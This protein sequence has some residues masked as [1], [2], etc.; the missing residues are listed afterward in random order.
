[1][2]RARR[3]TSAT[4]AA[5]ALVLLS[6]TA[7]GAATIEVEFLDSAGEGFFDSDF[8]VMAPG[9][10]SM[11]RGG[12]RQNVVE[13]AVA[14]WERALGS[15]VTITVEMAMDELAP[16]TASGGI[17]GHAGA[18]WAFKNFP[19]APLPSTYYTVAEANSLAGIDLDAGPDIE[20]AFNSLVDGDDTCFTT[21]EW[22]Y[23]IGTPAPAGKLDFYRVVLHEIG[24]GL[25]ITT[26]V[27]L[28]TGAKP[29]DSD[30]VYMRRL[31]D[32]SSGKSWP[33]MTNAERAASAKDTGD[34]HWIG[35]A[36]I[37]LGPHVVSGM[38][39]GGHPPMYAPATL[40]P[41]S[42]V[43][44]WATGIAPNEF[45]EPFLTNDSRDHLTLGLLRDIGWNVKLVFA[46]DF[47]SGGLGAW[48]A[49]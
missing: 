23:G 13:A 41:G 18:K 37:A 2:T 30:D 10:P 38:G 39:A 45:M 17:L 16:C 11:T 7:A 40:A 42:S 29:N 26:Y 9:N 31:E 43:S 36:A 21:L 5:V 25:G 28:A 49:P 27:D 32:H 8:M 20:A 44:H 47:E 48:I 15:G 33:Q 3:L 19:N 12:Q 6:S 4:A 22:W 46:D 1:M 14:Y 35:P 24:H 34:L